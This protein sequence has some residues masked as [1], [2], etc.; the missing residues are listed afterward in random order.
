[1]AVQIRERCP[2][3]G[4]NLY[5]TMRE[6]FCDACGFRVSLIGQDIEPDPRLLTTS[7]ND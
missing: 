2:S 4:C 5:E 6:Q 7:T 1:M 3:C